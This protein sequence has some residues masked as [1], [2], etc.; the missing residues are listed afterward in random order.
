MYSPAWTGCAAAHADDR[1]SSNTPGAAGAIC[2]LEKLLTAPLVITTT[3]PDP[4]V[5]LQGTWKLIC[6]EEAKRIGAGRSLTYTVAEPRVVGSGKLGANAVV[7]ASEDPKIVPRLPGAS[8]PDAKLAELTTPLI[9]GGVAAC[10]TG[11]AAKVV[12]KVKMRSRR[13]AIVYRGP[14]IVGHIC[15]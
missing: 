6:P 10:M 2:R 9:A 8:V 5:V 1:T 12:R 4:A 3:D 7:D 14:S 13:I 11:L 15:E